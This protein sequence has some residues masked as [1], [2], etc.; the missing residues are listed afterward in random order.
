MKVG[1][2]N[3]FRNSYLTQCFFSMLSRKAVAAGFD[4]ASSLRN[5]LY[6]KIPHE[7]A[8][9]TQSTA[10]FHL[11]DRIK[12]CWQHLKVHAAALLTEF[13]QVDSA[14]LS[15]DST[16]PTDRFFSDAHVWHRNSSNNSQSEVKKVWLGLHLSALPAHLELKCTAL[17]YAWI[18]N[19]LWAMFF[20]VVSDYLPF[21]CNHSAT[22]NI[23]LD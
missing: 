6:F 17:F 23:R 3:A 9:T 20:L 18:H 2:L 22:P 10:T 14:T 5:N 19:V 4:T 13:A 15:L 7:Y 1:K 11:L 21:S 16:T 8:V 12:C